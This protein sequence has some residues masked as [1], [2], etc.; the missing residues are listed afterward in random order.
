MIEDRQLLLPGDIGFAR[1]G[2]RVG[3]LVDLGQTLLRDGCRFTHAFMVLGDGMIIEAM[4]AGARIVTTGTG[5]YPARVG[6]AYAYARLP[7]TDTQR[8][9]IREAARA[10]A[11]VPYSFAD[12]AALALLHWRIPAPRLRRY[13]TTSRRM[14]CSQLCDQ[15][16]ADVGFQMFDDGRLPQDVTPGALLYR[17][18]RHGSLWSLDDFPAS[19]VTTPTADIRKSPVTA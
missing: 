9:G 2:G 19:G 11:G 10:Y 3:A 6:P 5:L 12:Y 18:I 17:S 16:L 4:P 15:I 14:I 13:I 8:A 1:I 7:L